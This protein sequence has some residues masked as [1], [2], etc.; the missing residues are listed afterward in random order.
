MGPVR[1]DLFLLE[2]SHYM[3]ERSE[4]TLEGGVYVLEEK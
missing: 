2:R 1:Y 3:E 4:Q